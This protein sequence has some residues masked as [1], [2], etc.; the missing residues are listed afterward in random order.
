MRRHDHDDP[1]GTE[2]RTRRRWRRLA[3]GLAVAVLVSQWVRVVLQPEGDFYLH[4]IFGK[5]LRLG[6]FL[7][8]TGMHVPYPPFW[9]VAS[10]PLSW[11][12]LRPMRALAYPLGLVPL[13]ALL[14]MLHRLV[15]D[16]WPLTGD[17]LFWATT[18][19]LVLG[20]RFL[21]RELP[22]CGANLA[23][24]ALAWGGFTLWAR[25]RDVLGGISLGA[26]IAL[27]CT[28]ALFVAYFA[29]KRQW[30]MAIA[31][32][33][34]A[35]AF[36]VAP[37]LWMGPT[38]FTN[39]VRF[40]ATNVLH[41]A[42]E[43]HPLRG[44]LGDEEPYN[45]SLRPAIGR[46][47][48]HLPPSHKGY[49]WRLDLLDLSPVVAG[50][51]AKGLMLGLVAAVALTMSRR[52]ERRDGLAVV[53]EAAAVAI[54]MLLLSPITWRQHGVAVLPAC[55]LIARQRAHHGIP[56]AMRR[57]VAIY[58]VLVLVLDRGLIGQALTL[59]LDS[60]GVTAWALLALLGATGIGRAQALADDRAARA[61]EPRALRPPHVPLETRPQ[62]VA[63][64]PE[65]HTG[66]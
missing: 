64:S 55:L 16:R 11:L 54:L 23:I 63:S 28:P 39:H 57:L 46:Y 30:R 50:H 58:V 4:W 51:V 3:I 66:V 20:S 6:G 13:A 9:A 61:D 33:C 43:P 40:W 65:S 34:A 18:V 45:L 49:P 27:K 35:L 31:S 8:A 29:W 42:L 38:A 12:P 26:A 32:I 10:A 5:R 1:S 15:R 44:I 24:V 36:S 22:E 47:L 41:G 19:G 7:Y 48:V 53:W 25:R 2:A 62:T 17:R 14:V 60:L 37:V 52:V 59:R 21:I 56:R